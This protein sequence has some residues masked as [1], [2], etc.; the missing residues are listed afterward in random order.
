MKKPRLKQTADTNIALRGPAPSSHLPKSAA[1]NPS[2]RMA[3]EKI[4]AICDCFQSPAAAL[5]TPINWL[6]GI[7]KTLKAYTC[8]IA[9]W[10]AS[11][12]GGTSHQAETWLGNGM[13]AIKKREQCHFE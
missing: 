7:L 6:R 12:A 4:Q 1:D 13:F 9:K 3:S 2:I 11:A 10:M 8:P 5:V